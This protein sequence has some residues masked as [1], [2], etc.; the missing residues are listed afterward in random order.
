MNNSTVVFDP[1]A[2]ADLRNIV[3]T[4]VVYHNVAITGQ[5]EWYPFAFFL[6]AENGE[7]LG[8]LLGDIWVAWL[9]VR[10]LGV[11]MPGARVWLWQRVDEARGTL[12]GRARLHRCILDTFSFQARPFL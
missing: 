11:A 12:C 6:R 5:T 3:Q 4:I 2:A 9:H 10:T 8:S 1:D 7:V